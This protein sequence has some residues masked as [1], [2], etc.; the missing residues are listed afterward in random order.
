MYHC[1]V[2]YEINEILKY[3]TLGLW[4]HVF[5]ATSQFFQGPRVF[6]VFVLFCLL[7]RVWDV[8]GDFL[9]KGEG[10][11]LLLLLLSQNIS[12]S[13]SISFSISIVSI[14]NITSIISIINI[15]GIISII[16]IIIIII[17]FVLD[18]FCCQH[19]A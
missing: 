2:L 1:G 14:F 18:L 7:L 12:I 8:L 6:G 3:A 10:L 5:K 19:F 15:I 16:S 17:G 13:I 4:L 9:G 11:L